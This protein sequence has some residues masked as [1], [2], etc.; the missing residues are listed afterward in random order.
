MVIMFWRNTAVLILIQLIQAQTIFAAPS[1]TEHR[2]LK[3]SRGDSVTLTCNMS[4]VNASEI[5]WIKGDLSFH[6]SIVLNAT[7]SNFSSSKISIETDLP[8]KL[9]ILNFQDEDEGFYNC[10]VTDRMGINTIIWNLTL[11]EKDIPT[12]SAYLILFTALPAVLFLCCIVSAVCLYRK[13][14]RRTHAQN[15]VQTQ[16][17]LSDGTTDNWRNNRHRREYMER[18]NSVYGYI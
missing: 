14:R 10:T 8:T 3:V 6:H 9:K 18:L 13:F 12:S 1:F 15:P 5:K 11:F 2:N 16:L 17:P 4:V 7:V